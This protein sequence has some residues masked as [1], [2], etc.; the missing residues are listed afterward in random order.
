MD[1]PLTTVHSCGPVGQTCLSV[2]SANAGDSRDGFDFIG[3]VW[4]LFSFW[5]I[6]PPRHVQIPAVSSGWGRFA[7]G[8]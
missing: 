1:K 4:S 2:V 5:W 7:L 3:G 6:P 8:C